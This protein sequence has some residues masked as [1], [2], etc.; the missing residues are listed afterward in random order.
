VDDGG[1]WRAGWVLTRA[2]IL[3][4]ED[5]RLLAETLCDVLLEAGLEPIGPA[6]RVDDALRLIET[7]K[8]DAAILDYQLLD[9][10]SS[11][12]AYALRDRDVPFMFLTAHPQGALAADLW[13][14]PLIGKPFR[15]AML[16]ETVRR[17]LRQR[18]G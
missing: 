11:P 10:Q 12:V 3:V 1:S 5:V 13:E 2:H 6:A 7:S 18:P 8:I 16:L 9:E 4:V 17:L 14:A 15:V